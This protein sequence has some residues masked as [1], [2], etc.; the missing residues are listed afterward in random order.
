VRR[1]PSGRGRSF[2]RPQATR[3]GHYHVKAA[4]RMALGLALRLLQVVPD[5]ERLS[6]VLSAGRAGHERASRLQ[7]SGLRMGQASSCDQPGGT[8]A[9]DRT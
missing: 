1:V 6:A 7:Y 2:P 3:S 5:Y 8:S 4:N 9:F